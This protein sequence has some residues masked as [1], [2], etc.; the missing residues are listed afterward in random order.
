MQ[1]MRAIDVIAILNGDGV[2]CLENVMTMRSDLHQGF[3]RLG[4]WFEATDGAVSFYRFSA[5]MSNLTAIH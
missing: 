2:H 5:D 4:L 1:Q 3:D